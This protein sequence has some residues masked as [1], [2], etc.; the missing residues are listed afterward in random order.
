[1]DHKSDRDLAGWAMVERAKV[2]EGQP[3]RHQEF[4]PDDDGAGQVV[5]CD[6]F[7]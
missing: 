5:S 3:L 7:R 6:Q 2:Q 4:W 1:M